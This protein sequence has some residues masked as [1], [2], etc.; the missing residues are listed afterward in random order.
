MG[1]E[2]TPRRSTPG[3]AG[4]DLRATTR[5]VLTPQM[6]VQPIPSDFRG[7]LPP[8]TVGLLL[9]HSSTTLIG[10]VIH[11]GVI[12]QDYEGQLKIMCSSPRGL[13]SISPGDRITQLLVLPSC[14]ALFKSG[15]SKRGSKGFGSSG[16]DSAY[17]MVDLE[18]LPT[19]ILNIEGKVFEG[20]LDTGADKSIISTKWWPSKWP[21]TQSSQTLQGL[22][23]DSSPAISSR[24]LRWKAPE[25]QEGSFV[26][27]VLPLPV[28]LWG[29]DVMTGLGLKLMNDYSVPAQNMM[30]DMGYI[31]GKGIGKH[32]Q[33]LIEPIQST[34]RSKGHG[35]GFS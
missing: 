14:H 31:P 24:S 8:N 23:Y 6:G 19:L 10:L 4:L 1:L 16:Q 2:D 21:V 20:I 15:S 33:G 12:D 5:V 28:N 34:V 22:G 29:R 30:M 32:H 27:Y 11:P 26:P 7:P 35:L 17:L 9:G 3:S 18:N 13:F 25:G